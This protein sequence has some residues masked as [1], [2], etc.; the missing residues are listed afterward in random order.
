MRNL[1]G[2]YNCL[3]CLFCCFFPR[4]FLFYSAF[5]GCQNAQGL[6]YINMSLFKISYHNP[7]PSFIHSHQ[8]ADN[9]E[10]T[11]TYFFPFTPLISA[12]PSQNFRGLIFSLPA[13]VFLIRHFPSLLPDS[14][15]SSK[16]IYANICNSSSLI[17]GDNASP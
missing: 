10:L 9:A 7:R 11:S 4:F 12:Y 14:T 1:K 2:L 16:Y 5:L 13:C 15:R 8:R 6:L 17:L 3:P